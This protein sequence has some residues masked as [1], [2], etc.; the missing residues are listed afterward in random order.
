MNSTSTI[1]KILRIA[2]PCLVGLAVGGYAAWWV[3]DVRIDRLQ[4]ELAAKDRD[5]SV[6]REAIKSAETTIQKIKADVTRAN[7][8]CAS[9]LKG[10]AELLKRLRDIDS[11]DE[12]EAQ[13]EK[14]DPDNTPLLRE[15]NRMFA[16]EAGSKD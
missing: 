9:R 10:N 14:G 15:L 2:C 4:A 11:L 8:I 13:N 7:S 6:C 5:I 1:L 3:Q 12:S 16:G